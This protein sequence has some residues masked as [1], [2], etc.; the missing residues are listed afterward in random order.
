M[1]PKYIESSERPSNGLLN[2]LPDY[3]P[4]LSWYLPV[5][6]LGS[7]EPGTLRLGVYVKYALPTP[8]IGIG[9]VL[10]RAQPPLLALHHGVD[11]NR[12]QEAKLLTTLRFD[13]FY[14]RFQIWWISTTVSLDLKRTPF[15]RLLIVVDCVAHF[16]QC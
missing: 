13:A 16:P 9:I 12:T 6:V 10:H 15:T 5:L 8:G 7:V 2:G 3:L 1:A 4:L 11:G 14:Q